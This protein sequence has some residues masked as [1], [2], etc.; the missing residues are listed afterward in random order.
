M[1][2]LERFQE[3]PP[4]DTARWEAGKSNDGRRSPRRRT[5]AAVRVIEGPG[6]GELGGLVAT[7]LSADGAFLRTPRA[8]LP[9]TRLRLALEMPTDP[10]PVELTARVVRVTPAGVG[11]RFEEVSARDRARLRG[12]AGF[13]EMDEAIVRVQRTLGDLIAG[14]LLPLG[15]PTEIEAVLTGAV[16]RGLPLT[17]ILPGRGFRPLPCRAVALESGDGRDEGFSTLRLAGLPLP[18]AASSGSAG[19]AA[20]AARVV[21][22]AFSDPPLSYA[23]EALVLEGGECPLLLVPERI[24]LNERRTER[25]AARPGAWCELAV[26]SVPGGRLRL[27]VIDLGEGGASVR[28]S[29]GAAWVPGL[30]LPGFTLEVDG[31]RRRVGGATVRYVTALDVGDV[32]DGGERGDLR[33][34]LRFDDGELERDAFQ[35]LKQASLKAGL[36]SRLTRTVSFLGGKVAGFVRRTGVARRR[37]AGQTADVEVVRYRNRLGSTV[38]GIVDANFDTSD[39]AQQPD[40]AVVIA[41]AILKRKEVFGLLARTLVDDLGRDGRKVAVLRFDASHIVGESTLDPKR[42]EEGRPYYDWTFDHLGAD[43]EAS[44]QYLERRFRPARRVLVSVSLSAIPARKVVLAH[45]GNTG[46]SPVDLWVAPYGCPD[47]QDVLRNYLAGLDL[48]EAYRRGEGPETI[49]I[50][51]RPIR[52]DNLYGQAMKSGLAFLE[53]A[54]RDLSRIRVPVV[55]ILGTYD[56]WVS[57]TRVRAMLDAPGGGVREVFECATGHVLK[58]GA[59]AIELFKLVSESISKHLF[60]ADRPARDPD[61]ARFARQSEAEWA[62]V[63]RQELADAGGFWKEHLFGGVAGGVGDAGD[64]GDFGDIGY[65]VLLEHPEYPRF[66]ARQAELLD[67]RPGEHVADFGCGTGNLLLSMLDSYP[68][69]TAP[70]SVTFLDLVPEA[71]ARTEEKVREWHAR[72]GREVPPLR[73]IVADLEV[74]RLAAVEDFLHGRLH[75][76]E[77][78]VDRVEGF[79][80]P[81]ARKLAARY[82][83][84]LHAVLRGAPAGPRRIAELCPGLEDREVEAVME[85]GRACRFVLGRTEPGD[86]RPGVSAARTAGDLRLRV[87]RFGD[88]PARARLDLPDASFDR[89]GSSLVL[90]YL[91]D[92][93]ASLR[94]MHRLLRPGGTLVLSSIRANFDPSKLYTEGVDILSHQAEEGGATGKAAAGKLAALRHFANMVSRLIELEE[95][96]RFRFCDGPAL[97]ALVSEAGFSRAHVFHAF[98]SPPTAIVVRAEKEL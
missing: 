5:L 41:P 70:A 52:G 78:L 64:T 69:G 15:E 13:Y 36:G 91:Y 61:L 60:G 56:G 53:D 58:T 83:K 92:P 82:G 72:H 29:A 80:L 98:G 81:A 39:P 79:S 32:G 51:G 42:V 65:D 34:G 57:R 77:G 10:R 7:D 25:R 45:A 31:E 6:V 85:I 47:A 71:V 49:L 18:A 97:T 48:F 95:D 11:I 68:A 35:D 43:M 94:E 12:H 19:S 21:Y 20:S 23:F 50:H 8:V 88:A 74:S 9:G 2:P 27:P 90:P 40:V 89:I 59:E 86:L 14:N 37:E 30:H 67:P 3:A 17:A 87:L 22:L 63:R 55:W 84:E 24:Y 4:A 16:E 93:L 33:A 28:L 44:L 38:A 75:G 76:I 73:G 96:G 54:R 46:G 26:P 62:R 1:Q 66:L